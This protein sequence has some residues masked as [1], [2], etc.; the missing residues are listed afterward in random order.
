[1]PENPHA[2]EMWVEYVHAVLG[3]FAQR[4]S[5][6]TC[7]SLDEILSRILGVAVVVDDPFMTYSFQGGAR[8]PG[9][10]LYTDKVR[11]ADGQ[12]LRVDW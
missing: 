1:M 9:M 11:S 3:Q 7:S 12:P 10:M 5:D 4:K 8:C 2:S 6:Q